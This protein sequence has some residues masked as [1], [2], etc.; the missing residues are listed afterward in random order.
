VVVTSENSAGPQIA[1][2]FAIVMAVF[3]CLKCGV[4]SK[5]DGRPGSCP[6]CSAPADE[7]FPVGALL[8]RES[9]EDLFDLEPGGAEPRGR[10]RQTAKLKTRAP[11]EADST[12]ELLE[13]DLEEA[14]GA[15]SGS[16]A[17]T[18]KRQSQESALRTSKTPP[19]TPESTLELYDSDLVP[20]PP[21]APGEA[22]E[23]VAAARSPGA[24]PEDTTPSSGDTAAAPDSAGV[25]RRGRGRVAFPIGDAERTPPPS[26]LPSEVDEMAVAGR[27]PVPPRSGRRLTSQT[28]SLGAIAARKRRR[29]LLG[30]GLGALVPLVAM[31]GTWLL[32]RAGTPPPPVV[33]YPDA[34]PT[35]PGP[36]AR[37]RDRGA[38]HGPDQALARDVLPPDAGGRRVP[39]HR[40]KVPAA[41]GTEPSVPQAAPS[42]AARAQAQAAYRAGF[43]RLLRGEN[44]E[45]VRLFNDALAKDPRYGVAHR[46]LGLAH[47]KL[48][49]KA[50]A[51]EAFGRYLRLQPGADDAEAIRQR[52]ESLKQ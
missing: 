50:M 48:G 38:D 1:V 42:P 32:G 30:L 21:P 25:A 16:S 47:E 3:R 15:P 52:I 31:G 9:M 46:G 7:A 2:S 4:V 41:R 44:D 49:R 13:A 26:T 23:P 36:D 29:V 39:T 12:L 51:R 33:E 5:A 11:V 10:S 17:E 18:V 34:R 6:S 24:P 28:E 37:P 8:A 43:Q 35:R 27:P 20:V 45:A 19:I 14:T 40:P 22:G